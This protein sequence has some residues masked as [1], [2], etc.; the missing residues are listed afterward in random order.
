MKKLFSFLKDFAEGVNQSNIQAHAAASAFYFFLSLVPFLAALI[1][2]IPLTGLESADLLD[3]LSVYLPDVFRD[4][5]SDIIDE[6]YVSSGKVLPVSIIISIW[7]ASRS[8]SSLIRGIEDIYNTPHYVSFIKRSIIACLFT[9]LML[10]A[11]ISVPMLIVFGEKIVGLRL[12]V[13]FAAILL[14]LLFFALYH[15]TPGMNMPKKAL[16]PG[17]LAA[18]CIW[19]LFS[20]LYSLYVRIGGG[21][22]VYGSLAAI[23]VSLLW[24]YWCMYFI[25]D[26]AYLNVFLYKRR[27]L[28]M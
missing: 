26:G 13:L 11:M 10:A 17:A 9:L 6:I 4:M 15:R 24:M 2:I 18:G 25:L 3:A 23:I 14:T 12:G 7:L 8:F 22:S 27:Y 5:V 21:Y 20:W 19:L 1:A 28:R 16:I